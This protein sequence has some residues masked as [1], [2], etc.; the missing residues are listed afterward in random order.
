MSGTL[1]AK[2][3]IDPRPLRWARLV[4]LSHTLF[5]LPWALS[6]LVWGSRGIPTLRT[7]GLVALAM[8]GARTAAMAW[9]R[10][11]DRN[12]D[13]TNPRTAGRPSVTG[14]VSPTEMRLLVAISSG[15]FI[16]ASFALNLLCGWLSLPTLALLLGYSF[17]KRVTL[18]SHVILGVC[19]GIS[20][21]GA[22]LAAAGRF[23]AGSLGA[24]LLGVGVVLWTAGFD[25]LY[26]CQDVEHDRREKLHSVPARIGV[27]KALA[28]S[29]VLHGL[30]PLALFAAGLSMGRGVLFY[31]GVLVVAMLLVYEHR[32]VSADDLTK[33]DRA[34]FQ[35]NVAIAFTML[36]AISADLAW[37]P[38]C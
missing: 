17:A 5:A 8:V 32:L 7:L 19:L 22:Y 16:A 35:A 24:F 31:A 9:N 38:A 6:G 13:R 15:C 21:L 14:A 29:R 11:V 12:L 4:R 23:D 28:L 2:P 27:A 10:L 20:P 30:L 26:A 3:R 33:I 37:G 34:F 18:F 25:I 36:L 1:E